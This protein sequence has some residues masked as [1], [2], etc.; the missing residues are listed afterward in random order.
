MSPELVDVFDET[1]RRLIN[2]ENVSEDEFS[3]FPPLQAKQL[4]N[5]LATMKAMANLGETEASGDHLSKD[6]LLERKQ[7]GEFTILREVG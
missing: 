4:R 6:H 5:Y 7:L 1:H 2:G 3:S